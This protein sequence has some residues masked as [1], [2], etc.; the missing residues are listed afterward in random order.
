[1]VMSRCV[2]LRMRNILDNIVEKKTQNLLSVAFYKKITPFIRQCEKHIVETSRPRVTIWLIRF[3]FWITEATDTHTH[4]LR[5][6][7][8]DFPLQQ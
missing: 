4:T 1:V 2:L 6:R 3:E 8:T 7:N 5:M